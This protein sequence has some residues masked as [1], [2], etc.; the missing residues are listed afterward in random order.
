MHYSAVVGLWFRFVS[1]AAVTPYRRTQSAHQVQNGWEGGR[2]GT[3]VY[4]V[5]SAA[6]GRDARLT[7]CY[8]SPLGDIAT[9]CQ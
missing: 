1:T 7:D 9:S 2:D 5:S 4:L 8:F 3:E 6:C